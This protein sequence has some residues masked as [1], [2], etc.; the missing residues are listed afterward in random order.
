MFESS[1]FFLS[2]DSISAINSK[3]YIS[4]YT[5]VDSKLY[6][7]ITIQPIDS[8]QVNLIGRIFPIL[9]ACVLKHE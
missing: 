3:L 6:V 7:S 4:I 2:Y 8:H 9:I 1:I 5:S